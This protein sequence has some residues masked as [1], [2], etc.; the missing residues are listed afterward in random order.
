MDMYSDSGEDTADDKPLHVNSSEEH[1]NSEGKPEGATK[2]KRRKPK[3]D[4]VDQND[5][6]VSVEEEPMSD[7]ETEQHEQVD[8]HMETENAALIREEKPV[9]QSTK[10]KL[11]QTTHSDRTKKQP[12]AETS[13]DCFVNNYW[14]RFL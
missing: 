2:A 8:E 6:T 11:K 4:P 12:K 5:V 14:M 7:C 10:E 13:K 1:A 3:E 9:G